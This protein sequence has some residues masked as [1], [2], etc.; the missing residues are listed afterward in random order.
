MLSRLAKKSRALSVLYWWLLEFGFDPRKLARALA[1]LPRYVGNLRR[2]R[3]SFNGELRLRPSLHDSHET[4][5]AVGSEYFWQDLWVAQK[6]FRANP[7]R[8]VDVGSRIDGFVA[9][10]ASFRSLEV[11]DIR[12]VPVSIPG[13]DFR[14][15]DLMR[16]PRQLIGFTPSLSCLHALEHFGLGRYGDPLSVDGHLEGMRSLSQLISLGGILYLGC[17]TGRLRV[18]F[19]SHRVLDPML[20]VDVG[21]EAGLVLESLVALKGQ[22]VFE[23][24]GVSA[25]SLRELS[26]R[27]YS[28]CIYV[29]RKVA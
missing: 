26:L 20:I 25:D 10:V 13:V 1:Q 18:E 3:K 24:V 21:R 9:H 23:D 19:D 11:L 28:L 17:P 29:F 5:G 16:P 2:F 6:I 4:A 14:Q 8:H 22:G 27:E 7:V 12:E 15:A